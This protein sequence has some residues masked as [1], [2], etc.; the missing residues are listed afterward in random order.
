MLLFQQILRSVQGTA[1]AGAESPHSSG[2]LLRPG[3]RGDDVRPQGAGEQGR[4]VLSRTVPVKVALAGCLS[5]ALGSDPLESPPV[6]LSTLRRRFSPGPEARA[7]PSGQIVHWLAFAKVCPA[8]VHSLVPHAHS[9]LCSHQRFH[10]LRLRELL[11]SAALPEAPAA[12][13]ATGQSSGRRGVVRACDTARGRRSRTGRCGGR[14]D[15][16]GNRRRRVFA[17]PV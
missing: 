14:G 7:S 8:L 1:A 10:A 16:E 17:E 12:G 15:R 3:L 11:I 9:S 4:V 13:L 5:A 6:V 2:S